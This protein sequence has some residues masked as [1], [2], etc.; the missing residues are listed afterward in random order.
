MDGSVGDGHDH[1][2][3]AVALRV[4]NQVKKEVLH[5]EDTVV[6]QGSPEQGMQHTVPGSI[7]HAG[8]AV[9]LAASA[10]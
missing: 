6:A 7:R 8:S 2:A 1:A 9:S 5:E 4:H 3:A 10:V